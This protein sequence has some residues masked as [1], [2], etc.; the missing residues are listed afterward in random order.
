MFNLQLGKHS[1][2]EGIHY[3]TEKEKRIKGEKTK[4]KKNNSSKH[5]STIDKKNDSENDPLK[6]KNIKDDFSQHSLKQ[7]ALEYRS[8][9]LV[10]FSL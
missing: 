8:T 10:S 6:Q 4:Q 3:A 9:E 1:G 7:C 2:P 5:T